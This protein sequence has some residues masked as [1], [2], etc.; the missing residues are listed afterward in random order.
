HQCDEESTGDTPQLHLRLSGRYEHYSDF[1]GGSVPGLNLFWMPNSSLSWR[2][3]WSRSF[4]VPDLAD[5][6][7]TSNV[8][9]LIFLP[10]PTAS[11]LT[12]T[13]L[14]SGN[15]TDLRR[16]SARTFSLTALFRPS[17]DP[18]LRIEAHSYTTTLTNR[19]D[20]PEFTADALTN[21]ATRNWITFGPSAAEQQEVCSRS[22]FIGGASS[23]INQPIGAIADFRLQ[24]ISRLDTRGVDVNLSQEF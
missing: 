13:L 1:G 14:W 7:E 21:P 24:N 12:P 20:A 15:N 3:T 23:C 11:N 4:R 16:S 8:S 10:N 5:L 9:T 17:F 19:I 22:L 18:Q 6:S 2:A